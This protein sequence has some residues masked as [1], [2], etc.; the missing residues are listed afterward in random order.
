MGRIEGIFSFFITF[1]VLKTFYNKHALPLQ[2]G[3]NNKKKKKSIN[4]R[5][6][7]IAVSSPSKGPAVSK[8]VYKCN[9]N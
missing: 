8:H 9:S 2:L 3:R 1:C 7:K 6:K 5:K 4:V